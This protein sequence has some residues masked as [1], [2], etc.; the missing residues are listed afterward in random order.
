MRRRVL[1]VCCVLAWLTL[2]SL[3][4]RSS[5]AR[6]QTAR[7]EPRARQFFGVGAQAYDKGQYL[8]AIDAFEQAYLLT[9]RP[10]LLFSLGQAHQ[11]QFRTSGD[12]THLLKAIDYYRKYL[13]QDGGSR[14]AAAEQGLN[15]LLAIS[16]RIHPLKGALLPRAPVLGKLLL[17]SATPGAELTVNGD[18]VDSLPTSLELPEDRYRVVANAK[19]YEPFVEDVAIA[20]GSS[21]PLNVELKPLPAKLDVKGPRAAEVLVDGRSMGWLPLGAITLPPG[22]HWVS[23]RKAGYQIRTSPVRLERGE[24]FRLTV[25]L[26]TTAQ[27]DATWIALGGSVVGA[28]LGGTLALFALAHDRK[29]AAISKQIEQG[30]QEVERATALNHELQTRDRLRG[31]A[32]ASSV[33]AGALLGTAA[34]LYVLDTPAAPNLGEMRSSAGRRPF[35][36]SALAGSVWGIEANGRF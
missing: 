19:G 33:S 13:A 9:P 7:D 8:L 5:P 10:G 20:A 12:D 25:T 35:T 36:L 15:L 29:A 32:I 21:V 26:R 17:S 27:R 30:D 6:A 24:T 23:V 11:H 16:A 22:E 4:N 1:R 34:V 2:A 31:Y 3:P 18:P 14:R 28:A